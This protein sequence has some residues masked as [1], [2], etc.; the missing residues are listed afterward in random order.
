[1]G[2]SNIDGKVSFKKLGELKVGESIT[3]YLM[4]I[5]DSSKIEG[6]KN[7]VMRIDGQETL[8]GASGNIK[9]LIKDNKFKMLANTRITREEDIKIKGKN[10]YRFTVEQDMEDMFGGAVIQA[11]VQSSVGEKL[12]SLRG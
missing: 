1:M 5:T 7:L 10:A 3:G 12:R 2:F 6:L 9:Y 11:P 4:A 8:V